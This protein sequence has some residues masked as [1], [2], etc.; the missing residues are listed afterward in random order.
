MPVDLGII[1]APGCNFYPAI[2]GAVVNTAF[3]SPTNPGTISQP[4]PLPASAVGVDVWV[5]GGVLNQ[6][7]PAN[8][9]GITFSN[10]VC[11]KV[12]QF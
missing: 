11:L 10:G 1:G 2:T 3:E 9:L 8:N 6:L 12:G 4:L 5:Q 7:F